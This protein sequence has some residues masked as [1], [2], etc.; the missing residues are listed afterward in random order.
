[1]KKKYISYQHIS[2][3]IY[4]TNSLCKKKITANHRQFHFKYISKIRL[5]MQVFVCCWGSDF[6]VQH[7]WLFPKCV[8]IIYPENIVYDTTFKFLKLLVF[9]TKCSY[10]QCPLVR[11]MCLLSWIRNSYWGNLFTF[12]NTTTLIIEILSPN[13]SNVQ[14][15]ISSIHFENIKY[16]HSLL[17][18][19][20]NAKY[21]SFCRPLWS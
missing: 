15:E 6:A 2:I 18:D 13:I 11:K 17:S 21:V 7:F 19:K 5:L 3:R 16:I 4:P 9:V 20:I 14:P 12:F 1:M 10:I 8:M